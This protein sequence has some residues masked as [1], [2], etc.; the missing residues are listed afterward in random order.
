M[1]RCLAASA[2]KQSS[3]D[4]NK[5]RD[6]DSA[7]NGRPQGGEPTQGGLRACGVAKFQDHPVRPRPRGREGSRGAAARRPRPRPG[8]RGSPGGAAPGR[9][10]RRP[11]VPRGPSCCTRSRPPPP[12][13][14]PRGIQRARGRAGS[15]ARRAGL[16]TAGPPARRAPASRRT[17]AAAAPGPGG[18]SCREAGAETGEA[19]ARGRGQRGLARP[20]PLLMARPAAGRR[21]P[22][23][24]G[25][26]GAQPGAPQPSLCAPGAAHAPRRGAGPGVPHPQ[27]VRPRRPPQP[28]VLLRWRPPP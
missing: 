27:L 7:H 1:E 16:S 3:P 11:R 21:L 24:S 14:R 18:R 19:S 26:S 5:P 13:P 12:W 15:A 4:Q 10:R 2:S 23:R 22:W 8:R 6:T 9:P 20:R 28:G 25:L 17:G